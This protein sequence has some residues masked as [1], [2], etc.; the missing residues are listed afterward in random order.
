VFLVA[1]GTAQIHFPVPYLRKAGRVR[2]NANL[3][4]TVSVWA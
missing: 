4:G 3:D 1:M 2:M